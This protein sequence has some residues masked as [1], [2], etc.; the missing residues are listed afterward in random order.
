VSY[1]DI[2]DSNNILVVDMPAN[3]TDR[4]HSLDISVSKS[5]KH[6]LRDSFQLWYFKEVQRQQGPHKPIKL[7]LSVLKPLGARWFVEAVQHV[8][9]NKQIIINGFDEA[10]NTH[11]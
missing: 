2:L 5:I 10:G 8:Q 9:K 1:V 3:C 7:K 6:H 11:T 4:L